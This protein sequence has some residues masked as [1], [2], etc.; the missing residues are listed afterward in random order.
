[1]GVA[2]IHVANSARR[3]V[4]ISTRRF[5]SY[6]STLTGSL[7]SEGGVGI[8]QTISGATG[9]TCT[10]SGLYKATDRRAQ[11]LELYTLG[12]IFRNFPGGKGTK[13]TTWYLV[14]G[15]AATSVTNTDGTGTVTTPDDGGFTSVVVAPG[16]A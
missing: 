15:T 7:P 6:G 8:M 13:G 12:D 2:L 10:K 3:A 9:T 1:M 4:R 5:H 16:A 14:S 11:Y